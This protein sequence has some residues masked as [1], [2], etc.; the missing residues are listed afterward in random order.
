MIKYHIALILIDNTIAYNN[1]LRVKFVCFLWVRFET[2]SV[3]FVVEYMYIPAISIEFPP[4]N[5]SLSY[6]IV[7]LALGKLHSICQTVSLF[8]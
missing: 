5:K 2:L 7:F 6:D 1:V 3:A 4:D 8:H